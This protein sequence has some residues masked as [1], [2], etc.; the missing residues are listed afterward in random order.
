MK[1]LNIIGGGRV[2]KVFGK[3]WHQNQSLH[4]QDIVNTNKDSATKAVNFIGA[5]KTCS[6]LNELNHADFTLITVP[7]QFIETMA[8]QLTEFDIIQPKD[9]VIHCSGALSSE[10]LKPLEQRGAKILSMHPPFS[11]A[12]LDYAIKNLPGTTCVLEGNGSACKDMQVLLQAIHLP[13]VI[14]EAKDKLLYHTALVMVSNYLVSLLDSGLSL[15]KQAGITTSTALDLIQPL[16]ESAVNQS[17]SLTPQQ[18]LTGPIDR[19]EISIIKKQL[20]LLAKENPD[21]MQLYKVLGKY[22]VGLAQRKH[23]WSIDVSQPLQDILCNVE[24]PE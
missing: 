11:F 3:L 9:I 1:S 2:G 23:Q 24:Q 14:I 13:S 12:D 21:I 20:N 6:N 22:T 17:F 7:D 8:F 18:A 19:N 16:V 15:L 10:V 5:G 4:I